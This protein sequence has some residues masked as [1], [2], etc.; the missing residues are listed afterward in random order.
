M[1]I[2]WT[3]HKPTQLWLQ[4]QAIWHDKD[5]LYCGAV[6]FALGIIFGLLVLP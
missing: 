5:M 6:C 1:K 3:N 4:K 2:T